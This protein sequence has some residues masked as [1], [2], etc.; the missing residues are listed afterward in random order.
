[1][2][3]LLVVNI[4]LPKAAYLLNKE[5]VVTGG[6]LTEI[7]E[8]LSKK[9]DIQLAV[10]TPYEG[11]NLKSFT[12]NEIDYY[13]LP[14]KGV[15]DV[16]END[17][18]KIFSVFQPDLLHIEGSEFKH[19]NTFINS[20]DGNNVLSLQGI[21]NG[22]EPYYTGG[23]SIQKLIISLKYPELIAAISLFFKK[24]IFRTR[25]AWERDTIEKAKN[26]LG[27][28]N[29]DFAYARK[30][31]SL[32]KY[33][34]ANRILR[35]PFYTHK[36]NINKIEKYSIYIGNSYQPIKGFHFVIHAVAK[37]K[38]KY[39]N[40]KI[41]VAGISPYDINVK[42]NLIKNGYSYYIRKL[43][44]R[45]DL[46]N[47]FKFLGNIDASQVACTLAKVHI[48]C[49]ASAIE[50]S[51]NTLGE[52]MLLGVPCVASFVGGVSDMATDNSEALLYRFDE[53]DVL[54]HQVSRIFDDDELAIRLSKNAREK[55]SLTH[56]R[57]D[58]LE[59][60]YNCYKT[61]LD[62]A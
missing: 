28:T 24:I 20:W 52:A 43:I 2:K 34:T 7:V 25:L 47:N 48:Y 33:Y 45:Y 18:R 62:N 39:P 31:N 61:I 59:K 5:S 12:I 41:Y 1:M 51:P 30:F 38:N 21:V 49:L 56:A 14:K 22:I 9:E 57:E 36:W 3:V 37:L 23:L 4:I 13:F 55:A 8:G 26:I 19:A 6:W 27:R 35:A 15:Y 32:A 54:V 40:I 29:W 42:N 46:N 58:N 17:C 60:I 16:F 53:V 10:A 11:N 44:E 50:N